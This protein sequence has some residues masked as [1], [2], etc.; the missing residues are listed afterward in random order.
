[1][2]LTIIALKGCGNENNAPKFKIKANQKTFVTGDTLH[3]T[4]QN[5]KNTAYDSIK[6]SLRGV[7]IEPTYVFPEDALLGDIPTEANV[8]IEGK[9]IRMDPHLKVTLVCRALFR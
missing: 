7:R 1:M 3:L 6:F 2:L 8:F 9:E 4:I 5:R